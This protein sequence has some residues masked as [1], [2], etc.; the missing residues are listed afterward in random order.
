MTLPRTIAG[1]EHIRPVLRALVERGG[2]K[3]V[4]KYAREATQFRAEAYMFRKIWR[5]H[6]TNRVGGQPALFDSLYLRIAGATVMVEQRVFS[7]QLQTIEGEPMEIS[8]SALAP[9]AETDFLLEEAL[10]LM[11]KKT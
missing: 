11:R 4:F 1:Y 3:V 8:A 7:G 9:P 2:G 5:Q 6:E 10:E